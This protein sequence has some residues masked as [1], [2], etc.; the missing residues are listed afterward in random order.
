[1]KTNL[2][3]FFKTNDDFEKNGVWFDV[4]D[5]IGFLVRPFKG[6]NPRV[7]AAMAHHYKP[8]A[9]QIELGTLDPAK[10]N[11]IQIKLFIDVSLVEWKGVE[12]D[13][14][15]AACTPENALKFF[16]ALPDLFDTLWR[17]ANDFTNYKEDL[18][19]S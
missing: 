19:N 10:Q 17:H 1:M 18:G 3:K 12:I 2:D 8:Y 6:S 15:P 7:K 9:R 14:K 5:E 11:E 16:L 4:S 13:D